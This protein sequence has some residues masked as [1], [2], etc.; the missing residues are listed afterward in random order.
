MIVSKM[1]R[2]EPVKEDVGI[3]I[4]AEGENLWKGVSDYWRTEPDGSLR[5]KDNTEYVLKQPV[6]LTKLKLSLLDLKA[7][8]RRSGSVIDMSRRTSTHVHINCTNLEFVELVNYITLLLVYEE[9]LVDWCAPSRKGN[10]FCLQSKDAEGL[11]FTIRNFVIREERRELGDNIRYSAINLASLAKY[12]S[13]EI[14]SLEGTV[15]EDRI[16][17]WVGVLV[18]LRDMAKTFKNPIDIISKLSEEEPRKFSKRILGDYYDKFFVGL[19]RIK[20]TID[21][22]RRAQDIAFCRGW[23][24]KEKKEEDKVRD[25]RD[26]F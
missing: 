16:L 13:V 1:F 19:K 2:V 5:G 25:I 20:K 7:Q 26:D 4:E 12:G 14:R 11:L 8:L 17:D 15:D 3:E 10:L 18:H 22:A 24:I 21:G 6:C 9:L 23:E